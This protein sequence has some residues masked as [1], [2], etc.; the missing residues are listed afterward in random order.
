M[1]RTALRQSVVVAHWQLEHPHVVTRYLAA[2][3]GMD[4][5][6]RCQFDCQT[7]AQNPI[8]VC[9]DAKGVVQMCWCC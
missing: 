9:I 8:D 2:V 7:V 6:T 3:H 1:R 4:Y 5:L